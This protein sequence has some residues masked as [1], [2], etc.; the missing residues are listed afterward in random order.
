MPYGR[1]TLH[2]YSKLSPLW[3]LGEG[4]SFSGIQKGFGKMNMSEHPAQITNSASK[5]VQ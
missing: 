4:Y 3:S 5:D 1:D 2:V